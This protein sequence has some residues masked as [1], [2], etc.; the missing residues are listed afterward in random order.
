MKY[1]NFILTNYVK[2]VMDKELEERI[3]SKD[4]QERL[5]K[6]KEYSAKGLCVLFPEEK[7]V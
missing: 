7:C 3:N 6:W 5:E 4:F 2:E 1:K